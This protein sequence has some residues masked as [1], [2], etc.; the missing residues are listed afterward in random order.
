MRRRARYV[1]FLARVI[2]DNFGGYGSIFYYSGIL[3]ALTAALVLVLPI[4]SAGGVE[5]T[6]QAQS[7]LDT[8]VSRP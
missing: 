2:I 6:G 7:Q 8:P 3:T 5:E 1:P 4:P